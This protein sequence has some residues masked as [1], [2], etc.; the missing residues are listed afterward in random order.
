MLNSFTLP[1]LVVGSL[2]TSVMGQ[3]ILNYNCNKQPNICSNIC[4]WQICVHPEQ[5]TY[6]Y[7][8][9]GPV[10][11]RRTD[12]GVTHNP[13][14]CQLPLFA[15]PTNEADEFPFASMAEGGLTPFGD[16]ASLLCVPASEQRG[17][18]RH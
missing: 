4:F 13:R 14:P 9:A 10:A 16:R 7:D 11:Q 6:T 3:N 15:D 18:P 2:A 8:S 1:V 12:C 5:T 17:K